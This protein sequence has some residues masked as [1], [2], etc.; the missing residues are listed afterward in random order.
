MRIAVGRQFAFLRPGLY[1]SIAFITGFALMA[2]E[3]VAARLLAPAIGTSMYVWTSVIGTMI[4]ALAL[5]YA[6]GG[7]IADKR[8]AK[9]DVAWLLLLSSLAVVST[10][11]FYDEVLASIVRITTDQRLQG[12]LAALLLFMPASFLLGAISPYLVRLRTRSVETTGRSVAGLSALN[13]IGG[14]T[15]TFVTGFVFFSFMGSRETIALLAAVLLGCS[16]LIMPRHRLTQRLGLSACLLLI[17]I[18]QFIAPLRASALVASIETPSAHYDVVNAVYFGSPVRVLMTGPTGFQ[19]GVLVSGSRELAFSYAQK[20]ADIVKA[21]PKKDSILILG[22]GALTLPDYLAH[23]YPASQVDVVEI[24]PQLAAIATQYFNYSSPKNARVIAEDARA[25]VNR[26][27]TTYDIV[28]ADVYSDSFIPFAL[29]TQEYAAQLRRLT[30]PES[31]VI[32]NIIGSTNENCLPLLSSLYASYKSTFPYNVVF[33]VQS[34]D[35]A[36]RQNI[37]AVFGRESLGWVQPIPGLQNVLLP[38][39]QELTDNF[40]PVESLTRQCNAQRP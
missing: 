19:S 33:P 20:I 8:T 12:V 27:S 37:I 23:T 39:G 6:A 17:I 34:P 16:W 30:A 21:A 36:K 25:Y 3:L 32:A 4:A 40:A 11:L 7:W 28:I 1:E 13:S 2:Y 24:D 31:T 22:G 38:A 9:Q 10:L 5:G 18:M 29:T 35:I 14:I 26:A 15:G